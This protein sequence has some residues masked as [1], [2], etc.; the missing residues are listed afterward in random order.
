MPA[1]TIYFEVLYFEAKGVDN[2]GGFRF[3]GNLP[4]GN[5]HSAKELIQKLGLNS[6]Q[7]QKMFS[8]AASYIQGKFNPP[9]IPTDAWLDHIKPAIDNQS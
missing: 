8:V 7:S 5:I 6:F 4:P 3:D 1:L 2:Y 9:I